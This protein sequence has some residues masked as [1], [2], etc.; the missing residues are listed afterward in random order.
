MTTLSSLTI[1][2]TISTTRILPGA[3]TTVKNMSTKPQDPQSILPNAIVGWCV[4]FVD[5]IIILLLSFS[6]LSYLS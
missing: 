5:F 3:W 6:F 4:C 1:L 2:R